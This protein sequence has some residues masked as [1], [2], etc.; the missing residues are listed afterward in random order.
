MKVLGIIES[1]Y[2][3]TIEE[4]DDT[5]VW[6]THVLKGAGADVSVL[7]R[8]NA[9]NYA[10]RTQDASGLRFGEVRQTQAPRLAHDLDGLLGKGVRV[11]VLT[12]DVGERGIADD[13]LIDGLEHVPRAGVAPLFGQ[14]DQ[15]WHW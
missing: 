6:F 7:L 12:E 1:A 4:Q 15:I 10:V 13:D 9:V 2:R 14:F 8:G 5:V 3:A 11:F